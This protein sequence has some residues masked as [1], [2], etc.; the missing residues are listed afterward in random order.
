[1]TTGQLL[2]A[3]TSRPRERPC[4]PSEDSL[5]T[6]T[7]DWRGMVNGEWWMVDENENE[8]GGQLWG[9]L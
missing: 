2:T 3:R 1:V 9:E 5:S 4:L 7:T 8:N 6:S